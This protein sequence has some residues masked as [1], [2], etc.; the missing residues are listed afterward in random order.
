MDAQFTYQTLNHSPQANQFL[1]PG[2]NKKRIVPS[3]WA[4]KMHEKKRVLKNIRENMPPEKKKNMKQFY[5]SLN[6]KSLD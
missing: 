4:E 5:Q 6:H 2:Y 1:R 3:P